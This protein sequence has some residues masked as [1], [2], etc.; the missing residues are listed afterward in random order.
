MG[1]MDGRV[2]FITGAARGQGR[3]HAVRL[4]QEGADI[5]GVDICRQLDLVPYPLGTAAELEET[6]ALV[7]KTG[8]RMI[9]RQADV[10]DRAALQE[11]FDAGVAEFGHIDTVLANAGILLNRPDEADPEAA[12]ELGIGVLLTGAWNTI[13]V[14]VPHLVERGEGG[15]IVVT[16]S[17]AGLRAL[18]DGTGGADAYNAAK[19]GVT[20]LVRAYGQSLA[21]HNIRVSAVAPTGVATPMIVDNPGLFK[22]IENNEHLA[23]A[24][25]NALPVMVI[26]P[27][28]VSEA[29]LFLV[30]DSGR[31]VTGST[32]MIDAGMNIA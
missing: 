13:R 8:R 32:L 3:S 9:T 23:K 4:A 10:R 26:E 29:I 2:A 31:Y 14:A 19:L 22:V 6:V 1:K 5:V 12:W 15:A 28:D 30:S 27:Q 17:M 16:S 11:A 21:R 7:E 24:M 25:T 20:G 18:T